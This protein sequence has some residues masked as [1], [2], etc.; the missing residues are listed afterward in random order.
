[1]LWLFMCSCGNLLVLRVCFDGG[2][3][4]DKY[5]DGKALPCHIQWPHNIDSSSPSPWPVWRSLVYMLP[6]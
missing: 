4:Y 1:M 2:L 3:K 5:V 6:I